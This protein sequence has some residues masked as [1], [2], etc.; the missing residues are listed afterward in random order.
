[1]ISYDMA[2][3]MAFSQGVVRATCEETIRAML[4]G[5]LSVEKT[6]VATD[7]TG[8]DYIATLRRGARVGIDHKARG[9]GC[10]RYWTEGPELALEI[11]SVKKCPSCPSGVPGWTLSEAK[12]TEYTLHTFDPADSDQAYLLPF[13]LL[14]MAFR[15]R[16][17]GWSQTYKRASQDSGQWQ[18]ECLFIPAYVVLDAIRDEMHWTAE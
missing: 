13:Q 8:I 1:M 18:S 2:E 9:K 7:K 16:F 15:R 4:T 6:D 10:S 17:A 11:W 14:R 3:R 5:C 12:V